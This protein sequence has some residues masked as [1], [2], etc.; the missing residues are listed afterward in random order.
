MLL[1]NRQVHKGAEGILESMK[2]LEDLIDWNIKGR[3]RM[4]LHI[5]GLVHYVTEENQ[6]KL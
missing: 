6:T 1:I 2:L 4:I 3:V 5:N